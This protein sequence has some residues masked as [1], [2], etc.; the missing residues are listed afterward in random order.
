[1]PRFQLFRGDGGEVVYKAE[2]MAGGY[3]RGDIVPELFLG[4]GTVFLRRSSRST[5]AAGTSSWV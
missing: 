1:M 4:G 2:G 5:S 3:R